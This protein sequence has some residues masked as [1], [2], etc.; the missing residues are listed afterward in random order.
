MAEYLRSLGA[1][2]YAVR[3]RCTSEVAVLN[4]ALGIEHQRA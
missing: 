3:T 2:E 4:P 1:K